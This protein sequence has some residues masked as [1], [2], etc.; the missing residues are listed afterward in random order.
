MKGGM[1]VNGRR[2]MSPMHAMPNGNT[3]SKNGWIGGGIDAGGFHGGNNGKGG[4]WDVQMMHE[5]D[6]R[7][8]AM[9]ERK[10]DRDERA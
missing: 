3:A 5:D 1:G 6:E 2:S 7:D 4:N 9:R 10:R 8:R